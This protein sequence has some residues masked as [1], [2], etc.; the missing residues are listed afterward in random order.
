MIDHVAFHCCC[1]CGDEGERK[2]LAELVVE[3]PEARGQEE[4][5]GQGEE[6]EDDLATLKRELTLYKVN[7]SPL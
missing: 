2:P 1:S 5:E 7:I 3:P 4:G 6:E